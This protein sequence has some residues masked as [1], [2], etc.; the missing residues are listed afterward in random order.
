MDTKRIFSS[1]S[2]PL[3]PNAPASVGAPARS[4]GGSGVIVDVVL[5]VAAVGL[6]SLL[7][8]E[9]LVGLVVPGFQ[10]S[11]RQYGAMTLH[12]RQLA[13][14]RNAKELERTCQELIEMKAAQE[15]I[16]STMK[17]D[18]IGRASFPLGDSIEIMS[19]ERSP[20]RMIVRGRYS[21]V[22][23]DRAQL[24]L[25]ISPTNTAIDPFEPMRRVNISK[26][27]GNFTLIRLHV[28]PGLPHLNMYSTNASTPFA[29]L[30]F[31]TKEEAA[32]ESKLD[33]APA[34]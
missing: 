19:V 25:L 16:Q 8:L 5:G 18:Y 3:E 29:K 14:E 20:G 33:L 21:L 23:A 10:E 17:S 32:E 22:S 6:V 27:S 26:G 34:R 1:G 9:L 30:C 13:R 7:F 11:G 15:K 31:G 12:G 4:G 24:A 2:K 28:T